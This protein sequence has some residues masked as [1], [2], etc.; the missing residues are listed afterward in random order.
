[1][2]SE[3]T[4]SHAAES[5]YSSSGSSEKLHKHN[6]QIM[7]S[8]KRIRNIIMLILGVVVR[9]CFCSAFLSQ[10]VQVIFSKNSLSADIIC[11]VRYIF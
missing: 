7:V 6:E 8:W 11:V 3:H 10:V 9:L 4:K 2:R 1:M 5:H